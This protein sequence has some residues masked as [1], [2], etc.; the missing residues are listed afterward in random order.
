VIEKRIVLT[1]NL[2]LFKNLTLN[3]EVKYPVERQTPNLTQISMRIG[4]R[5]EG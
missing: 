4:R 3:V 5:D 2:A 1:V